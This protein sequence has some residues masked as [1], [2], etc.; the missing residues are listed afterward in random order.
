MEGERGGGGRW[1]RRR[2]E[3]GRGVLFG[4]RRERGLVRCG[5]GLHGVGGHSG[6]AGDRWVGILVLLVLLILL[7]L[8]VLLVLLV[9]F[10][11]APDGRETQRGLQ[12][13]PNIRAQC[14]VHLNHPIHLPSLRK[15]T[16]PTL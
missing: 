9:V 7:I 13:M 10:S 2:G 16:V 4:L 11:I 3:R 8:L 12:R 5:Q 15:R 1:R 6:H 14:K